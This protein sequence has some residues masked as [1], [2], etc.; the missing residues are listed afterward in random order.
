MIVDVYSSFHCWDLIARHVEKLLLLKDEACQSDQIGSNVSRD[1]EYA[2]SYLEFAVVQAMT[3][4][5]MKWRDGLAS[6][7]PLRKHFILNLESGKVHP[8]VDWNKEKDKFLWLLQI[9]L[10]DRQINHF[11]TWKVMDSLNCMMSM[12]PQE[13]HRIT[14]WIATLISEMSL[15]AELSRQSHLL[16]NRPL[17]AEKQNEY[18]QEKREQLDKETSNITEMYWVFRQDVKIVQHIM[19]FDK[20][21][22]P[23]HKRRTAATT[24]AMQQAEETLDSF[25]EHLDAEFMR[26]KSKK[27]HQVFGGAIEERELA[28]TTDWSEDDRPPPAKPIDVQSTDVRDVREALRELEIR[29]ESTIDQVIAPLPKKKLKTRGSVTEPLIKQAADAG[30]QH[31]PDPTLEEPKIKV[32]KR[33]LAVFSTIFF[34]GFH[35][36]NPG[37]IPWT[38]FLHAMASAGFTNKKLDGSAWI[39]APMDDDFR[40]SIIFHEPHPVSK[41]P[42]RNARRMG[43]RLDRA[44]GWTGETFERA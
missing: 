35:G 6:S 3:R 36:D 13:K 38:E 18:S 33:A 24:K 27:L 37:E 41:I 32:S 20:L 22:Y 19:P 21:N 30:I 16:S 15:L 9:P 8:K 2:V 17:M 26:L 40:R 14:Q 11:G 44:F 23:Y 10:H 42:F 7:P 34:T 39:F 4:P 1:Y 5:L 29:S 31:H 28:R 12:A 25:W 43:R